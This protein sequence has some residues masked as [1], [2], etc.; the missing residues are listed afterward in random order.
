MTKEQAINIAVEW[1]ANKLSS[2][3]PHS[4][5]DNGFAS[6]MACLLAD[7]GMEC[8]SDEKIDIFKKEL[9]SQIENEMPNR[10]S[11][12]YLGVDYN[13]SVNLRESAKKAGISEFNFPFKTDLHIRWEDDNYSVYVYDG[14]G[15]PREFL[16]V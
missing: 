8:V 16:T 5:G 7:S 6:V 12:V 15:S 13:P 1:W 3:A 9:T 2:K 10:W 4:N 14:Y 11:E